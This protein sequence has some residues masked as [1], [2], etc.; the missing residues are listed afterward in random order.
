ME[1]LSGILSGR[2][3]G[4]ERI[5]G[6]SADSAWGWECSLTPLPP[7]PHPHPT[8]LLPLRV[9]PYP[10]G[11]LLM[12]CIRLTSEE[13]SRCTHQLPQFRAEIPTRV[14]PTNFPRCCHCWGLSEVG[15]WLWRE[16]QIVNQ[17][18]ALVGMLLFTCRHQKWTDIAE[19]P[20]DSVFSSIRES[21][22]KYSGME[23]SWD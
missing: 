22:E 6:I 5:R 17:E 11:I 23:R 19:P 21:L 9:W 14:S 13:S 20:W 1:R 12:V 7:Y 4:S 8:S 2:E 3:C 16:R 18:T 10:G 15:R